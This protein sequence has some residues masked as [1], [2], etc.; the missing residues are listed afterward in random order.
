M[1]FTKPVDKSFT[2]IPW[3]VILILERS[4]K[5]RARMHGLSRMDWRPITW[6]SFLFYGQGAE[7]TR[8]LIRSSLLLTLRSWVAVKPGN[9]P[10]CQLLHSWTWVFSSLQHVFL[11]RRYMLIT[12]APR[13]I[14]PECRELKK[15]GP[16]PLLSYE[17]PVVEPQEVQT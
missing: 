16:K 7:L 9:Q 15:K 8:Y 4:S 10:F 3:T 6:S 13:T 12:L 1:N 17:Q 11:A 5:K 2:H 14:L